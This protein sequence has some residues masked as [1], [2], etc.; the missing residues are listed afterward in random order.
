MLDTYILIST[1]MFIGMGAAIFI[2]LLP[3]LL[4]QHFIYKKL[5]DPAY[6]NN[7][8]FSLYELSIYD[9]FPLFFIKT[10]AYVR[11]I[12]FPKTMLKRFKQRILVPNKKP[13]VYFLALLSMIIIIYCGIV[14]LNTGIMAIFYYNNY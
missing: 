9:S 6:F 2:A 13:F 14:L 11:A 12:V 3:L 10:L 7:N 5:L 4:I 8:H 1:I